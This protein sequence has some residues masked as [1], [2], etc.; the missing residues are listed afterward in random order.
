MIMRCAILVTVSLLVSTASAAPRLPEKPLYF[1]TT[2]GDKWVVETA[3]ADGATRTQTWVVKFILREDEEIAVCVAEELEGKLTPSHTWYSVSEAGV[4]LCGHATA[5]VLRGIRPPQCMLKTPAKAGD[6]W[7]RK[8]CK[9]TTAGE[10]EVAVP[11]GRFRA[12]RVEMENEFDGVRT[13]EW[14]APRVGVVKKRYKDKESEF[15]EVLLSF[16]PAGERK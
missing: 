8:L 7:E 3:Q 5:T 6:S 2:V 14:L 16:T 9:W 11:A 4:L 13:T 10:E 15:T 12:V 1:P